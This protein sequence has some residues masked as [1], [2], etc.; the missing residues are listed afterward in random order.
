MIH[1]IGR[2]GTGTS[3]VAE[4]MRRHGCY[5]GNIED[6]PGGRDGKRQERNKWGNME[7]RQ[8]LSLICQEKVQ[9]LDIK[10]HL[11]RLEQ[12]EGESALKCPWI[13]VRPDVWPLLEEQNIRA[14]WL[15]RPSKRDRDYDMLAHLQEAAK[16]GYE[17][18]RERWAL[19]PGLEITYEDVMGNP[20]RAVE[21]IAE[22]LG[23]PPQKDMRGV[24]DPTWP[25]FW[26]PNDSQ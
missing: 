5:F 12:H 22:F 21:R 10:M 16:V 23:V 7:D 6:A 13:L 15:T 8:L 9:P 1:V 4:I 17:T 24:V 3:L 14:V 26:R 25:R 19:I 20:A 18:L 2:W 11:H